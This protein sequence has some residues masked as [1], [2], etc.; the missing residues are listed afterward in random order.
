M[1]KRTPH[2]RF[3]AK[4]VEV[5]SGCWMWTAARNRNGYGL[6][7]PTGVMVPAHRWAYEH[8]V[9]PIPE[10]LQLDHLCRVR[11]CVNPGHMEPVTCRENLMRGDTAAARNAA[12][13][14]CLRGHEFT[15]ENTCIKQDGERRCR[16]C[17]RI[18]RANSRNKKAIAA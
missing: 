9:G 7:R 17:Y 11:S 1:P 2:Q 3:L 8:Y 4:V 12:K 10:G 18:H 5:P 14:H 6:F 13:T 15:L 16:A